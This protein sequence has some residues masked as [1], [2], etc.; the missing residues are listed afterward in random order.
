MPRRQTNPPATT[1]EV[2]RL[3]TGVCYQAQEPSQEHFEVHPKRLLLNFVEN[4]RESSNSSSWKEAYRE[5]AP[6]FLDYGLLLV[7]GE[8]GRKSFETGHYSETKRHLEAEGRTTRLPPPA[9]FPLVPFSVLHSHAF[10]SAQGN[11]QLKLMPK[12]EPK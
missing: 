10:Y 3:H 11:T 1:S 9:F 7:S 12:S 4:F 5:T 6:C 2:L 8:L